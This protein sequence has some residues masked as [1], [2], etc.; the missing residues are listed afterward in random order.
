MQRLCALASG[1]TSSI[2]QFA[3]G[4]RSAE[5]GEQQEVVP[6][7]TPADAAAANMAAAEAAQM[8]LPES[9]SEEVAAAEVGSTLA[10][11]AAGGWDL[12]FLQQNAA[13]ARK[14]A[15]AAAEEAAGA[16]PAPGGPA[17]TMG[18]DSTR[19]EEPSAFGVE[20]QVAASNAAGSWGAEFLKVGCY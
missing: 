4:A 18:V 20:A 10:P 6:S 8:P 2:R 17:F 12:L 7:C 11:P 1:P 3:F 9:D 13:A 14:A 16:V 19:G 15:Y 5:V